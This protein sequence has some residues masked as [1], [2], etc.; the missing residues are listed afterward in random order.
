MRTNTHTHPC[1]S[2]QKCALTA[3]HLHRSTRRLTPTRLLGHPCLNKL[4]VVLLSDCPATDWQL[5]SNCIVTFGQL[6]NDCLATVRRMGGNF[7]ATAWR[8]SGACLAI[9]WRSA[10]SCL[11]TAWQLSGDC[12]PTVWPLARCLAS[13]PLLPV[14]CLATLVPV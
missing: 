4:R 11:A 1:T 9:V 2:T 5:A 7:P 6:F 10:G 8:L 12:L 3:T 14:G 13:V